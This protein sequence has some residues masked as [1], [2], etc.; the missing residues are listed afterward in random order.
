MSETTHAV[1][2]K[3]NNR[4][5]CTCRKV[6]DAKIGKAAARIMGSKSD[7]F[8]AVEASTIFARHLRATREAP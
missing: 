2:L 3:E 7:Y 4:I 1:A 5:I 6:C 8:V